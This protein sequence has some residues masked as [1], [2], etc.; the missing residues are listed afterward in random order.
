MKT[1]VALTL[2]VTFSASAAGTPKIP[3]GYWPVEKS[4]EIVRRATKQNL[5]R[6]LR[7]VHYAAEP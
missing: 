3:A 5:E 2:A 7:I 6:D 4:R 1:L